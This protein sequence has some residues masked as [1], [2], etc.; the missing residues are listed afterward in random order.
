L[1]IELGAALIAQGDLE[2]GLEKVQVGL[3]LLPERDSQIRVGGLLNQGAALSIQGKFDEARAVNQEGLEISRRIGD[4]FRELQ[5]LGNMA[6]DQEIAGDW[7]GAAKG[8]Q[9]TLR[10]SEELGAISEQ[11]KLNNNLGVLYTNLGDFQMAEQHLL[12]AL[13]LV[14]SHHLTGYEPY[15]L[16]G[17]IEL[18]VRKEAWLEAEEYLGQARKLIQEKEIGLLYP[19]QSYYRSLIQLG[20]GEPESALESAEK[21]IGIAREKE[22]PFEEGLAL[23]AQALSFAASGRSDEALRAF[24]KSYELLQDDPYEAARVQY[25]WGKFLLPSAPSHGRE[26][27][28]SACEVFRR[29]GAKRDFQLVLDTLSKQL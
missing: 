9:G 23:R 24:S 25:Q 12:K 5:I 20:Q 14:R 26:R 29:L 7:L 1:H 2:S 28:D 16:T 11:V 15:I 10:L 13:S 27:L 6:I 3:D 22:L 19:Y 18:S 21:A 4:R 17:L 8:H